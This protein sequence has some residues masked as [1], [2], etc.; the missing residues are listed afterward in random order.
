MVSYRGDAYQTTSSHP[1]TNS[2]GRGVGS[3]AGVIGVGPPP[4]ATHGTGVRPSGL[5]LTQLR[6]GPGCVSAW[7]ETRGPVTFATRI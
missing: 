5:T 2:G 3:I 7:T 4:A 6:L 1:T